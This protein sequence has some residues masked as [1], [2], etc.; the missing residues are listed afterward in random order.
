MLQQQE[1][2]ALKL[3][4][5][6][7]AGGKSCRMGKN[8]ALMPLSGQPLIQHVI[9]RVKHI[10]IELF[11]VCNNSSEFEFL[12]VNIT[13]DSISGKGAL[14]GLFTAMDISSNEYVAVVA[15]DLP[16][17]STKILLYCL[18]LLIQSGADAA[19]PKTSDDY[20]EPLHAVYR[21][22][23][24]KKAIFQAIMQNK[25]RAISWLPQVNVIEINSDLWRD[26]DPSGLAFFN[27]NT[28]EDFMEAEK[29]IQKLFKQNNSV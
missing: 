19:I 2:N 14:G 4:V 12:D 7:E 3:S 27:V 20:F 23:P 11:I 15:C 26:L 16:F 18:D 1:K 28:M 13:N 8:K 5:V 6:V 24:C 25:R 9:D 21:R 29:T 22:E 17:V 10:A